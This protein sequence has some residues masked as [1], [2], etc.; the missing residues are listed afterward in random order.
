MLL[1]G[2]DKKRKLHEKLVKATQKMA[3]VKGQSQQA[4]QQRRDQKVLKL[5]AEIALAQESKS[6]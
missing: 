6:D 3:E 5:K 1:S 4:R 2:Q